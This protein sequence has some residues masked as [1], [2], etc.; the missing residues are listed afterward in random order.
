MQHIKGFIKGKYFYAALAGVMLLLAANIELLHDEAYYWLFSKHPAAGYFDHPP[1]TAWLIAAGSALI[2]GELGVRILFVL[3]SVAT[4]YICDKFLVQPKRKL[5]YRLLIF[6]MPAAIP[7]GI[8]AVPDIPVVF[9]S[10]A[11][12]ILIIKGIKNYKNALLL[13][14]LLAA[15]GYSK[16]TAVLMIPAWIFAAPG[17][18]KNYRFYLA[19]LIALL[20][21]IPHLI[22]QY[23]H[24]FITILFHL[25][26]RGL[27]RGWNINDSGD[28]AGG[29]LLLTAPAVAILWLFSFFKNKRKHEHVIILT[30]LIF[31]LIIS[32]FTRTEANW[33]APAIPFMAITAA[34]H[35]FSRSMLNRILFISSGCITAGIVI[36]AIAGQLLHRPDATFQVFH[37]KEWAQNIAQKT[38]NKPI[39]FLNSYQMAAKYEFYSG[40]KAWSYNT[41]NGRRNQF[42]LWSFPFNQQ[43]VY[44]YTEWLQ[45]DGISISTPF[46]Q[47]WL[48]P[49]FPDN[50]P[51]G[52]LVE[53]A[54][55]NKTL[56]ASDSVPAKIHVMYLDRNSTGTGTFWYYLSDGKNQYVFSKKKCKISSEQNTYNVMITTPAVTG[57]FKLQGGIENNQGMKVLLSNRLNITIEE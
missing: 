24:S 5:F 31:C 4:F 38:D 44:F 16:Y 1:V 22:W 7:G 35:T 17:L 34:N 14:L 37:N 23:N 11:A 26:E 3:V 29:V 39:I 27:I 9:F 19:C 10:V 30:F 45:K 56:H 18:L 13:G 40:N 48:T 25:T 46:G 55:D 21:L 49:S 32:S 50:F 41:I 2:P 6:T 20:L 51:S 52:I 47:R 57:K 33:I 42:S 43:Q 8:L 53:I 54:I 36:F 15:M 28:F 12:S